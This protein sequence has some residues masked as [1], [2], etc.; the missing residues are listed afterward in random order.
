VNYTVT[1]TGARTL[2]VSQGE[3]DRL[4][5]VLQNYFAVP[6]RAS[7]PVFITETTPGWFP[8]LGISNKRSRHDSDFKDTVFAV[9]G[10]PRLRAR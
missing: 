1:L 6:Q 3:R 10:D 4:V 7:G 8:A 9:K 5:K 2:L